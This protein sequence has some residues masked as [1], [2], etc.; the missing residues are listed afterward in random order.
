LQQTGARRSAALCTTLP[1]YCVRLQQ[2]M[3]FGIGGTHSVIRLAP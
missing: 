1:H 3:N 2:G